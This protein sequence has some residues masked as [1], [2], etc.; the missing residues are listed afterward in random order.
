MDHCYLSHSEENDRLEA[1][2]QS[3]TIWACLKELLDVEEI[4]FPPSDVS[5]YNTNGELCSLPKV[6]EGQDNG[7]QAALRILLEKGD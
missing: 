1:V 4:G 3:T 2:T 5:I 7:R 6:Q